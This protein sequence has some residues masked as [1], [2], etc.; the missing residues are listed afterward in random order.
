MMRMRLIGAFIVIAAR[1][2]VVAEPPRVPLQVAA[3]WSDYDDFMKLSAHQ[4]RARFD[5]I[6]AENRAMIVQIHVKRWLQNNRL[7]LTVEEVKVFEEIIAFLN[8]GLHR[9]R[10]DDELKKRDEALR[11]RM[12]C[13]VSPDD[14]R[15][16][17]NVFAE[18][19]ESP[20]PKAEWTYLSQAKCWIWWIIEGVAD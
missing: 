12:N 20:G 16:A 7:R 2:V 4:R 19:G 17:T 1:S 5:A 11:A 9:E 6:S 18:A 14:V 8:S 10:P 13:R 15:E 3:S